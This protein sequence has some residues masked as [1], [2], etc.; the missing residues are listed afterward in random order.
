MGDGYTAEDATS[1]RRMPEWTGIGEDVWT[2]VDDG[3]E[4]EGIFDR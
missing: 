3:K 1:S 2:D 4:L